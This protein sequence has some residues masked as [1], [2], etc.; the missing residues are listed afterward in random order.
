MLSSLDGEAIDTSVSG[1][2]LAF[3]IENVG[4]SDKVLCWDRC[5]KASMTQ[6]ARFG[7]RDVVRSTPSSGYSDSFDFPTTP[8]N[9]IVNDITVRFR[10]R[11]HQQ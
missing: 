2:R 1:S 7:R 11:K 3:D 5:R 6:V 4:V 10:F 9:G 8:L